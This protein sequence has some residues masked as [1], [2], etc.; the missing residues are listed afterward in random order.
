[1]TDSDDLLTELNE[2]IEQLRA[3]E[4]VYADSRPVLLHLLASVRSKVETRKWR[5]RR[6]RTL[7]V[8]PF[9]VLDY[10]RGNDTR[11]EPVTLIPDDLKIVEIRFDHFAYR[12]EAVVESETFDPVEPG[13]FPPEW[14]PE[15]RT[16]EEHEDPRQCAT[17]GNQRAADCLRCAAIEAAELFEDTDCGVEGGCR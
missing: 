12:I 4:G 2:A 5:D 14:T 16:L 11:F 15:F 10:I 13:C 9:V 8:S 6:Y 3:G 17:H 7:L 1:M